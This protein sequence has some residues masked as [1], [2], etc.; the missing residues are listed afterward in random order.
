MKF[1]V[2]IVIEQYRTIK[3]M[4]LFPLEIISLQGLII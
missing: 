2:N 1:I 3:Q 4:Y